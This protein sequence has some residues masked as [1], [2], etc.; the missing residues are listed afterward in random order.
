MKRLM[1]FMAALS[2]LAVGCGTGAASTSAPTV[3]ETATSEAAT[4]APAP[5]QTPTPAP[6]TVSVTWD[7]TVCQYR[8]PAVFPRDARVLWVF[9]NIGPA[10][11]DKSLEALLVVGAVEA[12][13]TWDDVREAEKI[14]ASQWPPPIADYTVQFNA[15]PPPTGKWDMRM[16]G[17]QYLVAC[18]T[19]PTSSNRYTTADLVYVIDR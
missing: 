7:G 12:G 17:D 4:S 11:G 8:G 6:T 14:P 9:S 1:S 16:A 18:G 5:V 3:E 15:I 10:V 13:T 2:I 19:S